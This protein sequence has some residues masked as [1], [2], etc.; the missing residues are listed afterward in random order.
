M[1][2]LQYVTNVSFNNRTSLSPGRS[3]CTRSA[4]CRPGSQRS[5]SPS[6]GCCS[7]QR[8]EAPH[9]RVMIVTIVS[10]NNMTSLSPVPRQEE[11]PILALPVAALA[12]KKA[13]LP[14][15]AVVV[16]SIVRPP[17]AP[18]RVPYG[19][20]CCAQVSEHVPVAALVLANARET[21]P[22]DKQMCKAGE[23][24]VERRL[25]HCSTG[26]RQHEGNATCRQTN[27]QGR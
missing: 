6:C 9:A 5:Q 18:L 2:V 21:P 20:R 14:A 27:V 17:V 10:C 24:R 13:S 22:A 11:V 15:A 4:S 25:N 7:A 16:P 3:G 1:H 26:T 19:T 12:H 23:P 8:R